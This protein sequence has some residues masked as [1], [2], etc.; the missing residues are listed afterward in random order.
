MEKSSLH[1]KWRWLLVLS[2][3]ILL[4]GFAIIVE[5]QPVLAVPLP[6]APVPQTGGV[7]NAECLS[8]HAQ[9]TTPLELPSGEQ[10][11]IQIDIPMFGN[12]VHGRNNVTCVTC[13][14][15]ITGFPHP[16]LTAQNKQEYQLLY[17]GTCAA[18]HADQV[19]ETQDSIHGQLVQQG[20]LNAP[21]CADCHNPHTQPFVEE[22]SK[23]EFAEVC[24]AC[25]NGIYEEYAQS[26]H[27]SALLENNQDVPGC[28]DCHGVHNISD[29]TTAEF[30]NSSVNMCSECHTDANIMDKYGIS[31]NVLTTYV[32]D[33]HGTTVTLFEKTE[34]GQ[35][36]NK[37]VCYDCH[38]IHNILAVD[39][40]EKGLSVKQNMLMACQNCHPDATENFPDSWLGHYTPDKDIHPIVYYVTLFYKILIPGVL[41]GMAVY[42]LSDI[43]MR[44]RH[45]TRKPAS[46][47]VQT[48]SENKE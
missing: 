34:P 31:T 25:H 38:G 7:S 48:N 30:R 6:A 32:A 8:C 29:P 15:N 46:V 19:N 47:E 43:Y 10:L 44:I 26:V 14:S 12:S 11:F 5:A 9:A 4:T 41:G 3:A 27:G 40:P 28:V 39:D 2:I 13:H 37:A 1:N 22:V 42:I 36:T 24:A 45:K 16:K 33:F 17:P 35:I 23:A 20:D 18:C 21:T